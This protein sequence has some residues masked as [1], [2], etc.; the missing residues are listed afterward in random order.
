MQNVLTLG[1]NTEKYRQTNDGRKKN[2][3]VS[4]VVKLMS[5]ERAKKNLA[6]NKQ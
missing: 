1:T 6:L 3:Y 2:L 5:V 4:D